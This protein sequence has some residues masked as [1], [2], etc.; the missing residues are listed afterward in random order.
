M[1]RFAAVLMALVITDLS[2]AAPA[3]GQDPIQVTDPALLAEV[4]RAETRGRMLWLYDQAA[5]HAT[6]ELLED[7]DTSKIEN[8]RGYV[9]V[10]GEGEGTLETIFISERDGKLFAFARYLVRGS[11][12]T[13]GGPIEGDLPA[14]DPL[15]ERLFRAREPALAAMGAQSYSLCS[16][17][18]PNTLALPPDEAGNVVFY[19]L[20]STRESGSYP[21]GGHYRADVAADGT[22]ASTQRYMNTC[23]NLPTTPQRGPDG[24]PGHP[25]V[26]YLFGG[27]PSE[28]HVFA[29]F[30]FA[31][32]F[33]VIAQQSRKLWLVKEGRITLVQENFGAAE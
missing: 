18:S 1:H 29:S 20:T 12:V 5:W 14:L 2:I 13:G 15:A 8:P 24:S 27:A 22:V 17:E 7:V 10:P 23:F 6:D 9:V 11:E 33:M 4:E 31:D 25:G 3:A 21:I 19:L 26:S 32:G 30:Q 16:R 28:I